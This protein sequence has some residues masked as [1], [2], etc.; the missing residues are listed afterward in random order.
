MRST[1]CT[2]SISSIRP[3][4]D[5][6]AADHAEH[7]ARRAGRAVHVHA[8]LDQ[9]GD[10]RLDLRVR[11]PFLHHDNHGPTLASAA[12]VGAPRRASASARSASR[13]W[14]R[15]ASSMM[16]SYSR[17]MAS[18]SS[19]PPSAAF[20]SHVRD[21]RGL[22]RRLVDRPAAVRASPGRSRTRSGRGGRADGRSPRRSCRSRRAAP[23]GS[24]PQP[25]HVPLHFVEQTRRP[26][27]LG[28]HVDQRAAT[29]AASAHCPIARTC[30]G[31]EKPKPSAS[32]SRFPARTRV[33]Q[34][35][36]RVGHV[37]AHAGDAEARDA[38]QEAAAELGRA[39]DPLDRRRR[40]QAGKLYQCPPRRKARAPVLGFLGRHVQRQD[41][42]H[43]G[44][45][46][47]AGRSRPGP[48]AVSDWRS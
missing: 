28:D 14:I 34:L 44:A 23:R 11:R 19:G 24:A 1:S 5:L 12:D 3:R 7:D 31:R 43:A 17:A 30:S 39:P 25:S 21:H 18:P 40:A 35:A 32:G 22:A 46:R 4:I 13:R 10:H 38:V 48:S 27:V 9:V 45:A 36:R 47:P 37:V 29:T 8:E 20:T 2:P 26:A 6:A 41:A 15:R 33:G 16:R 42:V